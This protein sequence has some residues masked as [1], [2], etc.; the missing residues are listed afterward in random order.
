MDVKKGGHIRSP[1]KCGC[2]PPCDNFWNFGRNFGGVLEQI[3]SLNGPDFFPIEVPSVVTG[4]GPAD[5]KKSPVTSGLKKL[6]PQTPP[7][8][9]NFWNFGR[10]FGGAVRQLRF[11]ND[12]GKIPTEVPSVVTGGGVRRM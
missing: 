4:G 12:T 6:Y 1:K 2:P 7:P 10:N 3:K 9:N 8:S 5:V 11:C